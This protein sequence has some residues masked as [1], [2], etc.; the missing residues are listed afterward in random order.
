MDMHIMNYIVEE[1]LIMIAV[2]YVIGNVIKNTELLSDKWIPIVLLFISIVFTPL[3]IGV[4]SPDTIVQAI[5]VAGV[6]VFGDQ[7]VKQIRKG[8]M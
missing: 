1:G 8:E 7:I 3:V 2:L 5:L 4:Y 6:T